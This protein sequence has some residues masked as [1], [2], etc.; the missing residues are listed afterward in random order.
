MRTALELPGIKN[1]IEK[2]K[3]VNAGYYLLDNKTDIKPSTL[4]RG[5]GL[6]LTNN[7]IKD[8]AKV[9][10]SLGN[11]GTLLNVTT[12]KITGQEGRFLNFLR[13]LMTASLPLM[14]NIIIPLAEIVL[15]FLRLM[16]AASDAAI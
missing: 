15:V 13:Q 1:S 14:K 12:T 2:S 7:E 4:I 6:L 9:I 16:A 10:R 8:I 11:S 5:S 3:C